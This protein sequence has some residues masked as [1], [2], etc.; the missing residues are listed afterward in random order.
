MHAWWTLA[1]LLGLD[2]I[3]DP[4]LL[5]EGLDEL[6]WF[7]WDP[8]DQIGGWAFHLAVADPADGLAWALSAV[9]AI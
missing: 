1:A 2:D 8:G 5:G 4:D 6:R 3:D 7:R 9:D